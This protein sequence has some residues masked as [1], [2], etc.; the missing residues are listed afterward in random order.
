MNKKDKSPLLQVLAIS[1]AVLPGILATAM[2]AMG[3]GSIAETFG[4][5][6]VEFQWRNVVFFGFFAV[7]LL[8][9]GTMVCR[10][11][12]RKALIIG[13]SAFLISTLVSLATSNWGVFLAAQAA[14]AVADGLIVPAQM[15][16]LRKAVPE[17]RLG[18]A[19][20]W[21]EGTLAFAGL[22]GPLAG[23]LL[24]ANFGWKS[25]FIVVAACSSLALIWAA[26]MV[27]QPTGGS[28]QEPPSATLSAVFL[29]GILA[30]I[31]TLVSRDEHADGV[32]L[33]LQLT[34]LACA[35]SGLLLSE[36][37]AKRKGR[38]TLIPWQLLLQPL[39]GLAVLRI[40]LVFLVAN[41]LTL[42]LPTALTSIS[43]LT[44]E[45]IG[46]SLTA[47]AF[48]G[49]VLQP[50]LGRFAD[51]FERLM[52]VLGLSLI[53][54]AVL[55]LSLIPRFEMGALA[56]LLT[57]LVVISVG[58]AIFSPAQLRLATLAAPEVQ[59]NH[60]MGF[61]MFV[62]F[63]SGAFAGSLLGAIVQDAALTRITPA[64]YERFIFVCALL[65]LVS[66]L[67]MFFP[68]HRQVRPGA[69]VSLPVE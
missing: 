41:G 59:R 23:A 29:I 27:R 67:T 1:A 22:V 66:L 17:E 51:R 18:W 8:L 7:S 63:S 45:R 44:V 11:G 56:T 25:I 57:A 19:F 16:L 39:L 33:W 15:A 47:V 65:I 26:V 12:E 46:A 20:G 28:S 32:P 69:A 37:A 40:L 24:I 36:L 30:V 60:F 55:A 43:S 64:S 13:Q 21:F 34:G 14:Q 48:I 4:V 61:Y 6:Y 3:F 9:F 2:L 53:G 42:H 5:S 49:M 10:I 62:Q 35:A 31:Q 52:I 38:S 50:V 54:S 58:S 68:A